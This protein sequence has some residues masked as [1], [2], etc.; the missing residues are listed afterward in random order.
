[1]SPM[2][3]FRFVLS[4]RKTYQLPTGALVQFIPLGVFVFEVFFWSPG[5]RNL[6][7]KNR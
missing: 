1:M 2:Q 3:Q 6:W 5:Q 4:K 7:T